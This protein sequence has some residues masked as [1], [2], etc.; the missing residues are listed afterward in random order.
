MNSIAE[1]V[2]AKIAKRGGFAVA[3]ASYSPRLTQV[4]RWVMNKKKIGEYEARY[5]AAAFGENKDY[6]LDLQS[7]MEMLKNDKMGISRR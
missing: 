3:T 1:V 4:I 6:W 7:S 2:K 5:L